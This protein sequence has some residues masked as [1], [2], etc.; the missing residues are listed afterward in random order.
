MTILEIKPTKSAI[1]QKIVER[2]TS[3]VPSNMTLHA[4]DSDKL[5]IHFEH[6]VTYMW[7]DFVKTGLFKSELRQV[8]HHTTTTE[9]IFIRISE[10]GVV[11]ESDDSSM[12]EIAKKIAVEISHYFKTTLYLATYAEESEHGLKCQYCGQYTHDTEKCEHCGGIPL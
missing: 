12:D 8:P 1:R 7:N 11:I 4:S 3:L 9:F 6:P 5:S 10:L 2:I